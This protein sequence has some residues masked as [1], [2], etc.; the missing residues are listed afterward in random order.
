MRITVYL[1]LSV[2][3]LAALA[4]VFARQLAGWWDEWMEPGC[5]LG[6]GRR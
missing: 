6:H 4:F 5:V 3:L 2:L 1:G